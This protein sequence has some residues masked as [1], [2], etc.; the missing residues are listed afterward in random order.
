MRKVRMMMMDTM[1]HVIGKQRKA[2][3]KRQSHMHSGNCELEQVGSQAETAPS[4]QH[5]GKCQ[6]VQMNGR[7]HPK[8]LH[9]SRSTIRGSERRVQERGPRERLAMTSWEIALGRER[10]RGS[11][12]QRLARA[13]VV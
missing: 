11:W 13:R 10:D 5:T 4:T 7:G 9:A 8:T 6:D 3:R 2:L 1:Y 12:V